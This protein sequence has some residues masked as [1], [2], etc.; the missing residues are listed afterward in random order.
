MRKIKKQ[1]SNRRGEAGK[2]EPLSKIT[3]NSL[4]G[5]EVMGYQLYELESFIAMDFFC[6]KRNVR[7][8]LSPD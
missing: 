6:D 2:K 5:P 4:S 7:T 1:G 3:H 8:L